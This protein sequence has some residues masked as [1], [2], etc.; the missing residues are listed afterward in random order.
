MLQ[1]PDLA[2]SVSINQWILAILTFHFNLVHVPGTSH[3]PDGLS[4]R[5]PQP[6]DKPRDDDEEDDFDD[7]I[8]RIHGFLHQV[9]PHPSATLPRGRVEDPTLLFALT[10]ATEDGHDFSEGEDASR[11][12][13]ASDRAKR[14]KTRARVRFASEDDPRQK[15]I[16]QLLL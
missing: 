11:E 13:E 4:R 16:E 9:L 14:A 2:L 12:G 5:P 3:G 8:D 1:N 10:D 7:W 6:G 15:I